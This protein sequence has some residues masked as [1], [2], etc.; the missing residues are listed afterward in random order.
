MS[1]AIKLCT[2]VYTEQL[3]TLTIVQTS[4]VHCG[5]LMLIQPDV[6]NR[7]KHALTIF[8]AP[9][10]IIMRYIGKLRKKYLKLFQ[11]CLYNDN[12]TTFAKLVN[13]LQTFLLL[14][15]HFQATFI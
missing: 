4:K 1:Q 3:Y 7:L 6:E 2:K 9:I 12:P 13:D 11:Q 15:E 10:S 14:Y 5:H 8:K